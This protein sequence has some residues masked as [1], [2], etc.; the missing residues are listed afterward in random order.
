MYKISPIQL[1]YLPECQAFILSN[2]QLAS[3]EANERGY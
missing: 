2:N 1:T 3:F